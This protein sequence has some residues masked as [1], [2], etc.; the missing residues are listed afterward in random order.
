MGESLNQTTWDQTLPLPLTRSCVTL[1]SELTSLNVTFLIWKG[2]N[3]ARPY[4]A[5]LGQNLPLPPTTHDCPAMS[6][7]CL[8][9][10]LPQK[11]KAPWDND[12]CLSVSTQGCLWDRGAQAAAGQ[13]PEAAT[14]QGPMCRRWNAH[15]GLPSHLGCQN[16][17]WIKLGSIHPCTVKPICWHRTVVKESTVFIAGAKQRVQVFWVLAACIPCS[18]TAVNAVLSFTTA[19]CQ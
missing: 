19:W 7:A 16:C 3:R 14:G 12:A 9:F 10:P 13:D 2:Y 1:A 11:S 17:Y 5:F 15:L 18:T 4:G 8:L 6:F